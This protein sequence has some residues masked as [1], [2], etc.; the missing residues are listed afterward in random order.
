MA[1][2]KHPLHLSVALSSRSMGTPSF[3]T[4]VFH[5]DPSE[6]DVAGKKPRVL[7]SLGSDRA[8]P[9]PRRETLQVESR[10]FGG[11]PLREVKRMLTAG[12]LPASLQ[13]MNSVCFDRTHRRKG[14]QKPETGQVTA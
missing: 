1:G 5:A 10:Y 2:R 9:K 11:S 3:L 14:S 7:Q 4:G 6:Q 13:V 8:E 12:D